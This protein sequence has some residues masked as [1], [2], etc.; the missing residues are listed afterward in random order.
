[1]RIL[2][3]RTSALGDVVHCLPVLTALRRRFPDATIGWVVEAAIAPLLEGHPDLDE[4]LVVRLRSWRHHPFSPLTARQI[5]QFLGHLRRFAPE[6]VIDLMG[7]HKAGVLAALTLADH[8]LGAARAD[9]REPSS[10]CW[11]SQPVSLKGTHVTERS[12]SLLDPLGLPREPPD[13]GGAKLFRHAVPPSEIPSRYFLV[14]PGAAWAN[15]RYPPHLWGEVAHQLRCRTDLPGVVVCG[16]GEVDLAQAAAAASRGA[17]RHLRTPDLASL[18]AL[19]RRS[20]LVI[21][22][23]TGPIHLAHALELPVLCLMGP[24]SPDTHG[25]YG[26]PTSSLFRQLPCSFCHRRFDHPKACL[27]TLAP[28]LVVDRAHEILNL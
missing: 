9:R 6:T 12:L 1:M 25:P 23:D 13:F 2:L 28:S 20:E 18:A 7:N 27:T 3:I 19:M 11:I 17:L 24:T 4:L 16:P 21:G 5:R 15:K 22:S 10:A 14:H 8:R 26:S